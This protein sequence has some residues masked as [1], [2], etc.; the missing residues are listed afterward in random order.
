M[1][2]AP[3]VR[4]AKVGPLNDARSLCVTGTKLGVIVRLVRAQAGRG[5]GQ[6]VSLPLSSGPHCDDLGDLAKLRA[7]TSGEENGPE[8]LL[9]APL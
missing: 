7:D 9:I 6:D 1:S 8:I 4:I 2:V 3:R 5:R